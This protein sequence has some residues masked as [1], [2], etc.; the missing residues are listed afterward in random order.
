M[1]VE[2]AVHHRSKW[3]NQQTKSITK[4][5]ILT[6][7]LKIAQLTLFAKYSNSF[8]INDNNSKSIKLNQTT[9]QVENKVLYQENYVSHEFQSILY[10]VNW[11][12][13]IFENIISHTS[14][15][16]DVISII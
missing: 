13:R 10:Q 6:D 5:I 12:I 14:I 9:T 3:I 1:T 15:D 16:F 2:H 11:P 7:E 4:V 8:E